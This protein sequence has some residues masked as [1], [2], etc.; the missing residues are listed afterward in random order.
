MRIA[1]VGD[2][3]LDVDLD[4]GATRLSP[5][6]PVP[7]VD[8]VHATDRAG[9]AGLVA[10]LLARDGVEVTLIT[11]LA[12]DAAADRLRAAL[13]GIQLV[14]GRLLGPTPVKTR[15]RADGH[16][17]ARLDEA[18]R[19]V[20][21]LT[22]AHEAAAVLAS[23]DAVVVA[24][25]GRGVLADPG[26]RRTLRR[27]AADRPIVW[28]PHPRGSRPIAGL[29]LVT[30]NAAEASG[31]TGRRIANV[32]EAVPAAASLRQI[33]RAAA[34]G[35][36]LG[37]L[38]AVLADGR[39][40]PAVLP[41]SAVHGIDPCGAGDRLAAEA[42]T[43]LARG[44]DAHEAMRLGVDRAAEFLRAGG[45]A[46]L[47]AGTPPVPV[48]GRSDAL[49]VVSTTRATGGTVV[50]TGGCF[51]LL[52]AGHVR[53]LQAA[54][55]MGDCLIVCLNSDASVRRLKGHGRPI[56]AEPDRVDLLLALACVDAVLVFEEDTPVGALRRLAPDLWVKGGDYRDTE[57]P[58]TGV[59]AE[60]GGRAVSVP[61]HPARS[62]S[63]LAAALAAVG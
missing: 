28:D 4:G 57:I 33:W 10:T 23:A 22:L 47:D 11:A 8:V 21:A 20:P 3:L 32:A 54:R 25:Y 35:V 18:C 15:V 58:E 55:A 5:D 2:S 46:T 42:A 49:G 7:V 6:A 40:L 31:A 29:S 43:A 45:V 24:D 36:T 61:Q 50:A 48:H 63:A 41:V 13:V 17:V 14:A 30:P 19:D 44:A 52:H 16:A 53:T 39:H 38:G 59:L 60:W 34:V 27:A 51:D 62:S 26:L 1:V 12:D 56:I 9:G 37:P